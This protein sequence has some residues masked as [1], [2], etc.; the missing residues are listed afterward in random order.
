MRVPFSEL[1]GRHERHFRRKLRNGLFSNPISEY[2]DEQLLEVQRLDHEELIDFVSDLRD[3]VQQAV[4]LK[5]KEESQVVLDLTERLDKLYETASGLTD[6]QAGN[7]SAIRQLIAVIM[8]TVRAQ[9]SGDALAEAELEQEEEARTLHFAL[10]QESLVADFLHPKSVIGANELVPTLLSE[11]EYS[12]SAAL[13]LFDTEQLVALDGDAAR[14]LSE[15]DPQKSRFSDAHA[16]LQQIGN[17]VA[18]LGGTAL[19]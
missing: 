9:A 16:R 8:R 11:T 19:N 5:P 4:E 7:K 17:R 12:V 6:D 1:P 14:L 15:K 3:A 2:T 10:L 18:Q 13:E